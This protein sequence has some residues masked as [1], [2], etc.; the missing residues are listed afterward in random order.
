[1]IL[2]ADEVEIYPIQDLFSF[3]ND[4][5]SF[6][7]KKSPFVFQYVYLLDE[8]VIG[9]LQ[10]QIIYER[11]E[12]DYLIIHPDFRRRKIA[13]LLMD[14]MFMNLPK[15]ILNV[16]L[17]VRKSNQSAIS[18]YEKYGFK[19]CAVRRGYYQG[20]DGL[21]MMKEMML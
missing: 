4:H 18:L 19:E 17:E 3:F 7:E 14:F 2:S 21:L 8:K 6:E 13:S 20:E 1:M 12:L 15:E 9:F 16:T 5:S 10:Y 11:A